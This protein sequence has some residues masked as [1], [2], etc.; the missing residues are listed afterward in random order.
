MAFT[1]FFAISAGTARTAG[2]LLGAIA[3]I[4]LTQLFLA[5]F[6][7]GVDLLGTSVDLVTSWPGPLEVFG[8]RWLLIDF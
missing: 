6:G 4:G 1:I 2:M 3:A 5:L 7:T 8:G